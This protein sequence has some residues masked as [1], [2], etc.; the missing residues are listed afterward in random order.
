M[1]GW[2]SSFWG[3]SGGSQRRREG[4]NLWIYANIAQCCVCVL[5]KNQLTLI[6][7][8]RDKKWGRERE[9]EKRTICI[10]KG[11][12]FFVINIWEKNEEWR[13]APKTVKSIWRQFVGV[14]SGVLWRQ[15]GWNCSIIIWGWDCI[16]WGWWWSEV[17]CE[18]HQLIIQSIWWFVL[19]AKSNI[20]RFWQTIWPMFNMFGLKFKSN[21]FFWQRKIEKEL[22]RDSC[23]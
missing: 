18:Q 3:G 14:G 9:S 10:W 16:F 17:L 1:L 7:E 20:N 23:I 11:V 21:N 15:F 13:E 12:T 19:S 2:G 8:Q 5:M 4:V 22:S 6:T